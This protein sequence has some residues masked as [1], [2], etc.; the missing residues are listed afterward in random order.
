MHEWENACVER[1]L[2]LWKLKTL[3]MT[4]IASKVIMF[5]KVLEFK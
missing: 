3:M 1:G 5:E 2:L 4:K